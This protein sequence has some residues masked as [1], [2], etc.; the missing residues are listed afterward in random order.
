MNKS[1]KTVS[2]LVIALVALLL[3]SAAA[4]AA[5][6]DMA[7]YSVRVDNLTLTQPFSPP[8]FVAHAPGYNL[9]RLGAF[10]SEG[11]Q[12]I[13]ET[14]NNGPATAAAASSPAV[15]DVVAQN[16]LIFPG[17]YAMAAIKAPPGAR[18]SLATMLG[19]TNDGFTGVDAFVLPAG[20][21]VSFDLISYDAGTEQNNELAAYVGALGGSM[22]APT[23]FPIGNHPG[24]LGIGDMDPA[25]YGWTDPV[26]RVTITRVD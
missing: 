18:L 10:A 5:P 7:T 3:P 24:I 21:S 15:L 20:G 8:L 19:I 14:G 23:R 6:R 26:A 22:R 4:F 16:A 11:I 9:F 2:L 12:L 25:M 17:Q 13:A 1:R